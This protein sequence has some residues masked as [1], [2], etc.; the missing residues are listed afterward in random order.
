M[1]FW[2]SQWFK[3]CAT[4]VGIA[5]TWLAA[6]KLN[7]WAFSGTFHSARANWIFLPAAIRVIAVLLFGDL[8]A[9]GLV[10][11]AYLVLYGAAGSD[12]LHSAILA[13]SS[14]IAP[15]IAV[16]ALKRWF[17][18]SDTLAGLR[19]WHIIALSVACAASNALLLNGYLW[20]AGHLHSDFMQIATVFIGDF[21]GMAI[22]LLA[23]SVALSFALPRSRHSKP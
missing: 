6:F 8:G 19:P 2:R 13:I 15:L 11:G 7:E 4:V 3:P 18:I 22:V 20:L 9:L 5:V 12:A 23:L 1:S 17:A 21:L 16:I 10:V 14:G